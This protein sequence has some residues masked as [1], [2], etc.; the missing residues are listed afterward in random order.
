MIEESRETDVLIIGGGIAGTFAAIKA[1]EA[2]IKKVTLV[3]KGQFGKSGISTFAAG[4]FS[5]PFPEDDQ[6]GWFKLQVEQGE[7]LNNQ[8]WVKIWL[9]ECYNRLMEMD[10]WGVEFEKTPEGKFERVIARGSTANN[11]MKVVMFHGPQF[12]E[13]MSKKALASGVEVVNRTMI[14][15]FLKSDGRVVGAIGFNTIKGTFKAFKAKVTVTAAGACTYKNIFFGH[16]FATGDSDAMVFR[17]GGEIMHYEFVNHNVTCSDFD[18][19]GMNMFITL[20]GK[21]INSLGEEILPIYDPEYGNYTLMNR[22]AGAMALEVQAGRGPIYLDMTHFKPE[23]VRKLRVV[24]PLT[25]KVYDRAGATVNDRFIRKLPWAVVL[26]GNCAMGGGAKITTECATTL[27]GLYAGGDSAANLATGCE[28]YG[29]SGLPWAAVSGARAGECA[30]EEAKTVKEPKI[31]E[32]QI[33]ELV[34]F[35]SS[36][37]KVTNGFGADNIIIGIQEALF[38]KDVHIIM[39]EER[40]KKA[41][42]AVESIREEEVPYLW[43]SDIHGLRLANEARDIT[44]CAEMYLRSNIARKE[45]RG[46][47]IREDFPLRDNINWLKWIVLK[48]EAGQMKVDVE[49]VPVD[50]YKIKPKR[51]KEPHFIWEAAQRRGIVSEI[52]EGG[53]KWA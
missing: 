32:G 34:E 31:S 39:K 27:P 7:Y 23:E 2:G 40:L 22:W 48:K 24:V 13:A 41:L 11:P 44:T 25:M 53:V 45:S 18:T 1:K 49:D 6:E 9:D 30:A 46:T 8:D 21:F 20:G 37:L 33:K 51:A 16:K 4:V 47:T 26:K 14:T 12:M 5:A 17:A 43:T 42:A 35:A 36:P 10:R 15:D 19:V 52:T 28:S 29:S 50:Q 3:D 38:S